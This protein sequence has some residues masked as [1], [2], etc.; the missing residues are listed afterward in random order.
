MK[1]LLSFNIFVRSERFRICRL[2]I[3]CV[4]LAVTAYTKSS[5]RTIID[6]TFMTILHWFILLRI[7]NII[8]PFPVLGLIELFINVLSA[9]LQLFKVM[10]DFFLAISCFLTNLNYFRLNFFLFSFLKL[11]LPLRFII[12]HFLNKSM[13]FFP[14]FIIISLTAKTTRRSCHVGIS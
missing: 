14:I 2:L 5:L 7:K 4:K 8:P 10:I 13:L 12:L 6:W 9:I 3:N 1:S 11:L